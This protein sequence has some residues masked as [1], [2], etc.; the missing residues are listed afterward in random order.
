MRIFVAGATG[1][2]G[3]RAVARLRA[4]GHDVTGIARTP[5][6][7]AQLRRAGAQPLSVSLFDRDAL[8]DAV[9]GHDAV[10]NLATKIPTLTQSARKQGWAENTRIR[11]EGSRNLVDAARAA[12]ALVFV[13]ES[14]AFLYGEHGDAWI[15]A[16]TAGVVDSP[17]SDP[18]RAAEANTAR[19]AV[20]GGRGVV[21]RFGEFQ[22][23]DSYH[24]G[25]I[26][27][28]ARKGIFLDPA[29][30]DAY[31]PTIAV[32]DAAAA[33]V[34]ALDAP[35]GT[36]DIVDDEPITRRDSS[37]ALA[38]AVGRRRLHPP[39]GSGLAAA[40]A[41]P[42]AD[43][44]RVT[45]R[46]FREV[47]GWS[48]VTRSQ[49]EAVGQIATASGIEPALSVTARVLLW[50]LAASGLALGVYA[51]FFPRGFYDDF[52]FN[53]MWVM[54]DGPYNE[55]LI[56]DFGAMNLAL[57]AVTLAALSY[58]SRAAARAAVIGW[59]VFSIPHAVYHFRHLSHYETADK[60]GNVGSLTFAVLLAVA[61]LVALARPPVPA[62][63]PSSY[64]GGG[65]PIREPAPAGI[66]HDD[67]RG[68]VGPGRGD[69]GDQPGPG[70]S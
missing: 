19:F 37:A 55:H 21:L 52:P 11:V 53:R 20:N 14:I 44:Q 9:A 24:A 62:S 64:D 4:A 58:G 68:D 16:T 67:L 31:R 50:L 26:F 8:R 15:D 54:A 57:A 2:L 60:I 34:A 18:V 23:P 1:V 51:E 49:R 38:A 47:T 48:P 5:E 35:S 59:L 13:Q 7:A 30:P 69:R 61:A 36:Y 42:L 32:D 17:V 63:G 27:G 33:V 25:A 41:G 3:H 12:G 43:S 22:A 70:L 56:R 45:N 46:R 10:V 6:K 39:P 40:K 29:R 66:R 28:A 65:E